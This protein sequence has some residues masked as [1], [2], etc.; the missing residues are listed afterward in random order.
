MCLE[1]IAHDRIVGA[2]ELLSVG[3]AELLCEAG[4]A[5]HVGKKERLKASGGVAAGSN[6]AAGSSPWVWPSLVER[7][8]LTASMMGAMLP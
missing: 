8:S 4:R 5:L 1:R 6:G 3:V 2:D 7:K